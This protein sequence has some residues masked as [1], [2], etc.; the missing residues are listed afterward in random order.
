ML[1]ATEI[2]NIVEKGLGSL[3]WK[4]Q[5]EE[6]YEPIE[7]LISI[8]G[9]R[10]RPRLAV[11]CCNL[12][13]ENIDKSILYPALALEVFHGFTLIHDDIM[14]GAD[15]RRSQPTVHKKWDNNIAIL[16]GDV[17][18]IKSYQ[19]MTYAPER[20]L[21]QVLD[22]FSDTASKVCEGQQYDMNFERE[23]YITID[24]YMQMIGLKTAVLISCSAKIGAII[25]GA[26]SKTADALSEFAFKL[27]LAFQIKDDL[28]D[29]FGETAV[30]GKNIGGDIMSNKKTWLLAESMKRA[31]GDDNKEL[32]SLLKD[33]N[34]TREVKVPAMQRLYTRLGVRRDG[35]KAVESL[36]EE[37][38]RCIE[39]AGLN[40]R[41]MSQL[42]D[43]ANA[44]LNRE[45]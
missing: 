23:P 15:M 7:Y 30:F 3:D 17:M 4:M 1:S 33:K 45:R 28:L 35:D 32:E 14:D 41:Q 37:A 5:P 39:R 34:L 16:S 42:A 27:G 40:N 2:E 22:V 11:L 44:L 13:S 29:S 21:R 25:G 36:H 12:F 20:C 6:L 38:W 18:C 31:S 8:G 26:D 9:K 43:F 24:D 10:L 19:L